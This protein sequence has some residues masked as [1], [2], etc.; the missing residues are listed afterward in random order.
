MFVIGLNFSTIVADSENTRIISRTTRAYLLTHSS[1][2][3]DR[4]N[5]MVRSSR[6]ILPRT[7]TAL[8]YR[9]FSLSVCNDYVRPDPSLRLSLSPTAMKI[10]PF[11][12]FVY[13]YVSG[14]PLSLIPEFMLSAPPLSPNPALWHHLHLKRTVI[15]QRCSLRGA[16]SPYQLRRQT[17][18]AS[19]R[20][21]WYVHFVPFFSV[22]SS[23]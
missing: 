5:P 4:L 21:R 11:D 12:P 18:G 2:S 17:L 8:T 13:G 9:N 10:R 16:R 7:T 15:T 23:F 3:Q 19:C 20:S 1:V 22:S 6:C 14:V